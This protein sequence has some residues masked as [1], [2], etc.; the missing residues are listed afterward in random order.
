M[1]DSVDR[2]RIDDATQLDEWSSASHSAA[3]PAVPTRPDYATRL[4]LSIMDDV[5]LT[6]CESLSFS[7]L[8]F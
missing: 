2:H 3:H 6:A 1:T 4:S 5:T 7:G 8:T